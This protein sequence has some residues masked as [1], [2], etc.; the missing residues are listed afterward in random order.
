M[1]N[2]NDKPSPKLD[3]PTT[4]AGR[5]M[6]H[7]AETGAMKLEP[8][9]GGSLVD[10]AIFDV[11]MVREQV[12]AIEREAAAAALPSVERLARRLHELNICERRNEHIPYDCM[13]LAGRLADL[14]KKN[15]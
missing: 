13:E 8:D 15:G 3:Q 11:Q 7:L 2:D 1:T 5:E 6:V 4:A 9:G 12:L 10:V 14:E